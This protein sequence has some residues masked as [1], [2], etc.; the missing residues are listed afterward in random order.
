MIATQL[1]ALVALDTEVD[2]DVIEAMLSEG[3]V[4]VL[5]YVDLARLGSDDDGAGDVLIVACVDYTPDVGD[6]VSAAS[7][8]HPAR[9]VVLLC[10]AA[11]NGYVTE[12]FGAGVDDIVALP[13]NGNAEAARTMS[14]QVMFTVEKAVAR[15]RGTTATTTHLGT[16]IAVLGLK[17]GSGKTLTAANLA[18]ALADSGHRVTIVDLDLQFGDVGLA[19]GLAPE[20]TIFDLISSGGSLDAEKVEDFLVVHP[21]GARALLAPAR[22]DQAGLVTSDFLRDVYA[23]LREVNDFVIIDT[24]PSFTAEVI[25]AVDN[26]TEICMVAMLDSLSLKNSKL[27]LETLERMDFDTSRIRLVLNRA[28]SN[29]GIG[30]DDV[31]AIVGAKPDVLVPSDRNVTRSINRGEPIVLEQRRSEAARAFQ[32]LADLYIRDAQ[33]NGDL[34]EPLAHKRRRRLFRRAR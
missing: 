16:M 14:R 1:H 13:A 32:S 34:P 22:P 28:D 23:V 4:G 19:L 27:G 26:S 9:P 6:Y 20:R 11:S 15:K 7:R 17:G 8:H 24:P 5:D 3:P 29:V 21:S 25:A 12:A 2:R 18:A 33:A 31:A 30:H 10:P